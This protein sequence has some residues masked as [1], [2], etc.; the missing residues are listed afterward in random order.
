METIWNILLHRHPWHKC[1]NPVDNTFLYI[2]LLGKCLAE[3]NVER[4]VL[5]SQNLHLYNISFSRP[6]VFPCCCESSA[7]YQSHGENRPVCQTHALYMNKEMWAG[8]ERWSYFKHKCSLLF[9]KTFIPDMDMKGSFLFDWR[10]EINNGMFMTF[11]A[12]KQC[13]HSK[14]PS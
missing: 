9:L 7:Q 4:D 11:P 10:C 14:R 2:A 5:T 1:K 12:A 6:C 8:G 3:T 13:K